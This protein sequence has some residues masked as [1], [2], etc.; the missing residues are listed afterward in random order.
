MHPRHL[1]DQGL[2][3]L[4]PFVGQPCYILVYL[5]MSRLQ[6]KLSKRRDT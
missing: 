1:P 5:V 2:G 6:R 3:P 4:L